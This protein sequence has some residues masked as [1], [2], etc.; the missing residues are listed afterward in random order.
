MTSFR[1]H[2]QRLQRDGFHMKS[3]AGV[4]FRDADGQIFFA[5][6]L[7]HVEARSYDVLYQ[8]L[9]WRQL[10]PVDT[11]IPEG[12]K[13]ITFQTFDQAGKIKFGNMGAKSLPRVDI[14]GK[15]TTSPV[16]WAP[17]S[18]AYNMGE[19]ASARMAGMPL[20]QRKAN[21]ARR[22]G[23]EGHNDIAF[24]GDADLGFTG[25]LTTGNGIPRVTVPDGA[26]TN[27]EWSTKTADEII[28]DVNDAFT[29]VIVDSKKREKATHLLLPIAQHNIL[30]NTRVPGTDTN[31]MSYLVTKVNHIA[32]PDRVVMVPELDGAGTAGVDVGIVY[33]RDPEK[34]EYKLPQDITF[35]PVQ[36]AGVEWMVPVTTVSGGLVIRYPL[37]A[38]MMEAI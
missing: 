27:P 9:M 8:E 13:S 34:I 17:W 15:E 21:A 5:R 20:E 12:A 2:L 22:A 19:I 23:E 30:T 11:A 37:S 7:E 16:H 1:D 18:F 28:T 6:E 29:K 24:N 32:G 14:A 36:L 33:T 25:L 3:P 31:L 35:H 38:G 4:H 10:F 26:S